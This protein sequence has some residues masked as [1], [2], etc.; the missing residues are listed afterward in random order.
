MVLEQMY[1]ARW[2]P[3][4]SS[5]IRMNEMEPSSVK[6]KPQLA[7]IPSPGAGSF[8]GRIWEGKRIK[9]R[10]DSNVSASSYCSK[11]ADR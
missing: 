3:T 8:Q 5:Q 1:Y 9:I 10:V 4:V 7:T 11:A 6:Q 2:K